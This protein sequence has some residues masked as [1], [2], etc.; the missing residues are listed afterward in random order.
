MDAAPVRREADGRGQATLLLER[1]PLLKG[2]YS[3]TPFLLSEDGLHPY[4]QVL[5]A[6]HI[7]V[8]QEGPLQGVVSLPRRWV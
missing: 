4:D 1:L 7:R 8:S 3:L 2:R 6:G 5:H